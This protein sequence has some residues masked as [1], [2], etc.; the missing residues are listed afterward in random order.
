MALGRPP[1]A[2]TDHI[3]ARRRRRG[4]RTTPLAALHA[5]R[6]RALAL[7]T[8]PRDP[9]HRTWVR[10]ATTPARRR[11]ERLGPPRRL[12]RAPRPRGARPPRRTLQ[13][14][15][16]QRGPPPV[17][18][19]R[20]PRRPGAGLAR[21]ADP[22]LA[23]LRATSRH[24]VPGL[25]RP[26][27]RRDAAPSLPRRGWALRVPRQVHD[28]AV[29]HREAVDLLGQDLGR[30]PTLPEVADFMGVPLHQLQAVE[31]ARR[32]RATASLDA[33]VRDGETRGSW[34][35]PTE[36]WQVPTTA[37]PCAGRSA[38][39]ATTTCACSPGTSSRNSRR[40]A[41]PHSSGSARCRFRGC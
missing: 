20:A 10:S 15:R 36:A 31:Q 22:G 23:P 13:R 7:L 2:A 25:R 28:L 37:W 32:A 11:P 16:A 9:V 26:D 34:A 4:R 8:V 14:L 38:S 35:G 18:P 33:P 6:D 19:R 3:A 40:P 30:P 21:G 1:A 24:P 17:P 12:R 39:W 41:S 27:R 5:A 29:P